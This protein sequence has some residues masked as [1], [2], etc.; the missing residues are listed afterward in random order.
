MKSAGA[1]RRPRGA[2][3][4]GREVAA[5]E[6]LAGGQPPLDGARHPR[7][8]LVLAA[9]GA[10]PRDPRAPDLAVQAAH[11]ALARLAARRYGDLP[12]AAVPRQ[13]RDRRGHRQERPPE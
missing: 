1:P 2:T 10:A 6:G 3:Y 9:D 5:V 12:G 11:G 13:A 4:A 8:R 7:L